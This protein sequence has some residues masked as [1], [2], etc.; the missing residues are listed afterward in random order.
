MK[1]SAT[2]KFLEGKRPYAR[3]TLPK[4]GEDVGGKFSTEK[5]FIYNLNPDF[6]HSLEAMLAAPLFGVRELDKNGSITAN[7]QQFPHNPLNYY[8]VSAFSAVQ[9]VADGQ[10]WGKQ[11]SQILAQTCASMSKKLT[12]CPK[13]L[14][15]AVR[16]LMSF[17]M[18]K[19]VLGKCRLVSDI[20][21]SISRD[22]TG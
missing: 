7:I 13:R 17:H 3:N 19:K 18:P 15:E 9:F 11:E 14:A 1:V 6:Y 8:D 21:L 22:G 5:A 16:L 20:R 12:G 4:E 2:H 10:M